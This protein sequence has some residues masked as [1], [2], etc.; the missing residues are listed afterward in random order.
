MQ[1]QITVNATKARKNF[2]ELLEEV[3]KSN[4]EVLIQKRGLESDV[5]MKKA[6]SPKLT[7]KQI[8]EKNMKIV[9]ETAGSLKSKIPY[10]PNEMELAAE[11]FVKEYKKKYGI[12]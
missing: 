7:R 9:R 1:K 6:K 5:I 10:Q 11:I 12:K 3:S 4:K 8:I 2:F